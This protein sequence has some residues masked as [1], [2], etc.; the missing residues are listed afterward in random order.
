MEGVAAAA[1]VE[2]VSVTDAGVGAPLEME[3]LV[4]VWVVDVCGS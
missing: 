1:D 3:L 4:D 2:D